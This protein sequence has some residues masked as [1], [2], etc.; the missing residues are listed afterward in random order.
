MLHKK[1]YNQVEIFET[2]LNLSRVLNSRRAGEKGNE[3]SVLLRGSFLVC[4]AG[5]LRKRK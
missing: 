2:L 5:K 4:T 1:T 3:G